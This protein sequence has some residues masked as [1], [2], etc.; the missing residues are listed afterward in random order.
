MIVIETKP[1]KLI[2]FGSQ[3]TDERRRFVLAAASAALLP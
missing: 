2:K 3:L 1:G